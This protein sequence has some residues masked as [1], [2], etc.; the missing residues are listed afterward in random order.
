M[1]AHCHFSS[2]FVF[3]ANT[4]IP[5]ESN[6]AKKEKSAYSEFS[7]TKGTLGFVHGNALARDKT[8]M[9]PSQT[10]GQRA[11]KVLVSTDGFS[12]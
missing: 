9:G 4:A 12:F 1:H 11:A 6:K 10:L 5:F 2:I 8:A 3:C 7:A